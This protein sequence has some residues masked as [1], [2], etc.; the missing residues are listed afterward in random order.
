MKVKKNIQMLPFIAWN[1]GRKEEG[2]SVSLSTYAS[3]SYL[4]ES[5]SN[6]RLHTI[7]IKRKEKPKTKKGKTWLNPISAW[8]F[9]FQ[10]K[11]C[12][13][14][15]KNPVC[16]IPG[17][18]GEQTLPLTPQP[19]R[20]NVALAAFSRPGCGQV[21]TPCWWVALVSPS[22]FIWSWFFSLSPGF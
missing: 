10:R 13:F 22:D 8:S 17:R 11:D 21:A 3:L 15:G 6:L 14:I 5:S 12:L 2:T 9:I 20:E 1:N 7:Y 4:H 16:R 19:C 18:S